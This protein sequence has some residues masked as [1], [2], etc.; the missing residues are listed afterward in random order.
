MNS[1]RNNPEGDENQMATRQARREQF[2]LTMQF[3]STQTN[4]DTTM[5]KKRTE[6][7]AIADAPTKPKWPESTETRALP[8]P[9]R[10]AD[11]KELLSDLAAAW[12]MMH[13]LQEEKKQAMKAFQL[14]IEEQESILAKL[15]GEVTSGTR[16]K[17]VECEWVFECAGIGDE[18]E[19]IFHPDM[20]TLFRKDTGD[21]VETKP[22]T[23]ADREMELALTDPVADE[24]A[25]TAAG[26][27]IVESGDV[28][29][30]PFLM[31]D[32]D[33]GAE[34]EVTGSSRA[35]ALTNAVAT[36]AK[37]RELQAKS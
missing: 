35:E 2:A 24:Q 20:K 18:G 23:G 21:A 11:N 8:C 3:Q 27:S 29:R 12:N 1:V 6:E 31:V 4:T 16:V 7:T 22:I 34:Y 33:T 36:L 19:Q 17:D 37:L 32:S 30:T 26:F 13:L 15:H 25:L 14:R 28:N 9:L 10:D 5:A